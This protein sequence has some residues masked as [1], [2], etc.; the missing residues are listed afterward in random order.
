MPSDFLFHAKYAL[1]TY[2]QC[3][4]LD[5]WDINNHFSS[6]GAECIIGRELHADG[7]THLHCFASFGKKRKFRRSDVF[8]VRGYHPNITPSRGTPGD[9]YDYA[10]KDGAVVAGGLERPTDGDRSRLERNGEAI[11]SIIESESEHDFWDA[12]KRLA[13]QLLL[14]NFPSLRAYASWRY[15]RAA[16]QYSHPEGLCVTSEIIPQLDE[17]ST[18]NLSGYRGTSR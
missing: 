9:G 8:D 7:G 11:H 1:I 18:E 15:A 2:A 17:W 13:P 14:R 10:I 12:V 4:G 6:L 5:P 3:D 16:V